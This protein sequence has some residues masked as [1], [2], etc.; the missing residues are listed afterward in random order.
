MSTLS[1]S[2]SWSA[3]FRPPNRRARRE[4]S[5]SPE[6][7]SSNNA[8]TVRRAVSNSPF[9][10]PP[11]WLFQSRQPVQTAATVKASSSSPPRHSRTPFLTVAL[12]KLHDALPEFCL[13]LGNNPKTQDT[14]ARACALLDT[15]VATSTSPANSTTSTPNDYS[16]PRTQ[17]SSITTAQ[18]ANNSTRS[19]ARSQS[20]VRRRPNKAAAAANQ[21]A[22]NRTMNSRTLH[23]R[24]PL[25]YSPRGNSNNNNS[26]NTTT[27]PAT[28]LLKWLTSS[29]AM[30]SNSGES[31]KK[32]HQHPSAVA[33]ESEWDYHVA[34]FTLLTAAL[35][36]DADMQQCQQPPES[37]VLLL[38]SLYQRIAADLLRVQTTLCEPLMGG[39]LT[40]ASATTQT[41]STSQSLT[42]T[43]PVRVP[44]QAATL[45]SGWLE[46]LVAY[47]TIRAELAEIEATLFSFHETTSLVETSQLVTA[48]W[49]TVAVHVEIMT[50]VVQPLFV[51]LL[52]E[53]KL[54][55]YCL[56]ACYALEQCQ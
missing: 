30:N 16:V 17:E 10:G 22:N 46:S 50:S 39:M 26:A 48:L 8:P 31:S 47:C 37:S 53:C 52:D 18:Q 51:S 45:V 4:D 34:P 41:A 29:N 12:L 21:V 15:S 1:V 11:S 43:S 55:K 38:P 36:L 27:T 19:R 7:T 25:W 6:D 42:A 32:H 20:P 49:Q 13:I 9:L 40:T 5:Y 28:P 56:E 44:A 23:N 24:N 35:I 14:A 2:P 3:L 54:W 33:L